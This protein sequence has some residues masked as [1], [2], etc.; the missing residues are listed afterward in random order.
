MGRF[1]IHQL[2]LLDASDSHFER[3]ITLLY[4]KQARLAYLPFFRNQDET[5]YQTFSMSNQFEATKL[6]LQDKIRVL[7]NK[8]R[9]KYL[10]VKRSYLYLVSLLLCGFILLSLG[11]TSYIMHQHNVTMP[12]Y[13]ANIKSQIAYISGQYAEASEALSDY[14]MNQLTQNERLVLANSFVKLEAL[15]DDQKRIIGADLSLASPELRLN[16][17]IEIGRGQFKHALDTAQK[18][19]DNQLMIY[20]YTKLYAQTQLSKTISGKEKQALLAEYDTE[21]SRL[22][23]LIE[24]VKKDAKKQ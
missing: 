9:Q 3:L 18:L 12:R 6:F 15:S 4:T 23:E 16:Y 21:M 8:E 14:T 7:R 19:D 22:M 13:Q 10:S 17:W 24:V 11:L 20:S 5:F 1:G 2:Y